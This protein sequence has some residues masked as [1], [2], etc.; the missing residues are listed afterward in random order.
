VVIEIQEMKFGFAGYYPEGFR[1]PKKT[2]S[3][4]NEEEIIRHIKRM[5]SEHCDI[6]IISLHWGTE[7]VHYPSPNQVKF[8]RKLVDAGATIVLGHHPHVVQGIENYHNGLIAYSLG[9]FQFLP[10]KKQTKKSIILSVNFENGRIKG[11]EIIPVMIDE[12][13]VP[14]PLD[15]QRSHDFLSFINDISQTVIKNEINEKWWFEQIAYEYL[16]GNMKA[17]IKRIRR[18]GVIH[19]LQCIKWLLSPFVIKCYWA[20][21]RKSVKKHV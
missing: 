15:H 19:L 18:Y 1:Y 9:N 3:V 17:W 2:I 16:S 14:H 12:D 5:R 13:F 11:Y 8:A 10:T 20:L 6:V 21:L 7:N 4:G